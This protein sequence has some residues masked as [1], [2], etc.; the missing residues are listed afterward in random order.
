MVPILTLLLITAI[1]IFPLTTTTTTALSFNFTT[2]TN[3]NRNITY[4]QAFAADN[5]IQLTRNLLASDLNISFGRATYS[6]PLHLWESNSRN[7]TQFQTHFTFSIF[8]QF[9]DG[10]G[11][12]LAFF[13]AP[14]GSYLPSDLTNASSMGL[15]LD[16]QQLNNSSN[17]F[18]AV[19]FDIFTNN[20]DPKV[21][22]HVG[23]DINSMESVRTVPWGGDVIGGRKS[24]AWITYDPTLHNLSVAVTGFVENVSVIHRLSYIVDLRDYLPEEVTFGFSGATGNQS[25]VHRIHS[26]DFSSTLEQIVLPTLGRKKKSKVGLVVGLGIGSAVICMLG[27]IC[28]VL[29][30]ERNDEEDDEEQQELNRQLMDEILGKGAGPRKFTFKELARATNNFSDSQNKLGEGGFGG[31][32]R[33]FMNDN[34]EYIAVKRVSKNSKQGIK[35]FAAEVKIISRLSHRNLVRLIGWCYEKM[36]LLLVYEFLP[37]GSLDIH[38]FSKSTDTNLTWEMRYKIAKGLASSLLYLH[39][40]WEQCVVHRDIKSSN[41]MLDS[42]FNAKLGDFGLARLVDHDKGSQTTLVAGTM[43]YL[44]PECAT[45][46]K[47]NRESDIYSFGVVILEIATGKRP[48][49][50]VNPEEQYAVHLTHWVWDLFRDGRLLVEAP[51]SKLNGDFDEREMERLLITGLSCAHP[52]AKFRP[53]IRQALQVINLEAPLPMLPLS[54]PV[55]TYVSD[56]SMTGSSIFPSS[57]TRASSFMDSSSVDGDPKSYFSCE[58][59]PSRLND[60]SMDTSNVATTF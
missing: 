13:L 36:E 56:S 30:R 11:D 52:N 14:K 43:G 37:N 4:E 18:V 44:A 60:S 51:D 7:L 15:T 40:E 5:S 2:F 46:G 22:T 17:R 26:W 28:V 57:S 54:R 48:A 9:R 50:V 58:V 53:S 27:L 16:L 3:D 12:G 31:V 20:F 35:E 21:G 10:Y 19:E 55:A 59:A 24:D 6:S 34:K 49:V 33:G 38:L 23:I 1:S 42:N 8:S 41:I 25:A 32:Y 45:T 39:E 47:A 29:Y